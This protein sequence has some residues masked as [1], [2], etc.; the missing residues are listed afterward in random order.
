[1]NKILKVTQYQMMILLEINKKNIIN[2][3]EIKLKTQLDD[4]D[5]ENELN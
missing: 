2:V 4:D 1:M 5:E 3:E